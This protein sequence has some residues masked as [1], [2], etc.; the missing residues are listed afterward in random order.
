ME[1]DNMGI[2]RS[3]LHLALN[4]SGD[5]VLEMADAEQMVRAT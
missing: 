1:R 2:L 4:S 5:T 3:V